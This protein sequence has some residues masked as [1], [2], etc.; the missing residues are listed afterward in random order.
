MSGTKNKIQDLRD[1]LFETLEDLKDKEAPLDIERA[2]AI[3]NVAQAIIHSAKVEVDYLRVT[4][5]WTG[6]GFLPN[7][8][9]GELPE[10]KKGRGRRVR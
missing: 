4:G 6:S 10:P 7:E 8:P 9:R 3:A 1:H 5:G 2:K